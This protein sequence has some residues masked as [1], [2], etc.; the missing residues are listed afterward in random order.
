MPSLQLVNTEQP[1]SD[2]LYHVFHLLKSGELVLFVPDPD[3][4]EG[5]NGDPVAAV[6]VVRLQLPQVGGVTW[7]GLPAY[8]ADLQEIQ[9]QSCRL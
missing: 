5:V 9:L 1:I 4:G 7:V 8:T 3:P 6:S 2:K